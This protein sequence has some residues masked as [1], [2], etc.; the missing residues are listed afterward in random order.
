[1]SWYFTELITSKNKEPPPCSFSF[2]SVGCLVDTLYSWEAF[3]TTEKW[4]NFKYSVHLSSDKL[5]PVARTL[6]FL[7]CFSPC[8]FKVCVCVCV[9]QV[10]TGLLRQRDFLWFGPDRQLGS[11]H[12]AQ[13]QAY[14]PWY[15]Q[16]TQTH[17]HTHTATLV[18]LLN[19][20]L[21]RSQAIF[22]EWSQG[23]V[24]KYQWYLSDKIT[25]H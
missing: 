12:A 11:S 3:G 25:E 1:M 16:E 15:E 4:K 9:F 24:N 23:P 5:Q 8:G 20:W 14:F 13:W 17:T 22:A 7:C 21:S 6:S 10:L 2:L 19:L 18:V